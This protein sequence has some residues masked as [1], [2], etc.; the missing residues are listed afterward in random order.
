MNF[1][2]KEMKLFE[3]TYVYRNRDEVFW[4]EPCDLYCIEFVKCFIKNHDE[5]LIKKIESRLPKEETNI[6]DNND[7]T[8]GWLYGYNGCL[9][10]IKEILSNFN[11]NKKDDTT[12]I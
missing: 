4:S 6:D 7:L 3:K 9:Q 12:I 1:Y 5:R 8:R 10:E 11:K 2:E